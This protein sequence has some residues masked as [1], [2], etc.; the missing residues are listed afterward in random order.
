M[1]PAAATTALLLL[2]A[3]AAAAE[4]HPLFSSGEEDWMEL[5]GGFEAGV[6]AV[7]GKEGRYEQDVNLDGG[8]RLLSAEIAGTSLQEGLWA[9]AFSLSVVGLGDPNRLM[10]FRLRAEDSFDLRVHADRQEYIY[11]ATADP[12]PWDTTRDATGMSLSVNLA[13]SLVLRFSTDRL[14]REGD[15]DVE[16]KY[17]DDQPFPAAAVLDYEGNFRSAGFDGT[18]GALRF[19]GTFSWGRS[20]DDSMRT[21]EAPAPNA[22]DTGRY[23]NVSDVSTESAVGRAGW[24]SA[25][26]TVDVS[27]SGGYHAAETDSVVRGTEAVTPSTGVGVGYTDLRAVTEANARG[28]FGRAEVLV[29]P[30]ADWEILGRYEDRT[31]AVVGSADTRVRDVPPPQ[32]PGG[33]YLAVPESTRSDADL[34]RVGAE[35]RWR[36][37]RAWRFR[38]GAEQVRERITSDQEDRFSVESREWSPT[39]VAA[40]AGADWSPSDRFDA[41][42]LGRGAR[43]R[44]AATALSLDEGNSLSL[45]LRARR[46]DGWHATAFARV[47]QRSEDSADAFSRYDNYGYSMGHA[48]D[49]R[50]LEFTI[51]RQ[52]LRT[53]ADTRFVVDASSNPAGSPHRL[54][55]SESVTAFTVGLSQEVWGPLRA[56]GSLR[57]ADGDG[58]SPYVQS[59]LSLGVGWR[60]VPEA[61]LRV[62]GRRVA[63]LEDGRS[64]DD[65]AA[66]ILTVSVAYEF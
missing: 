13:K 1:R 16:M 48:A 39:T 18:S 5:R 24:K 37:S 65:Y 42:L 30:H 58:D 12:N 20:E 17:R 36:A 28:W 38:A 25:R 8:F 46:P 15:G 52:D 14:R 59:D 11:R 6:R 23:R 50:S 55:Y 56:F 61:E 60:F 64:V 41:S 40:T 49:D 9:D 53:S 45:R 54:R 32:P 34:N 51:S 10:D 33:P 62:E 44:D 22:G 31:D 66:K 43:A 29:L 27:V 63:Y 35:A 57:W 47:K 3:G 21:L 26:G 2:A 7:T 19:G 4:E